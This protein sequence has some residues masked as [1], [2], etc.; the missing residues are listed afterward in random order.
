MPFDNDNVFCA[1]TGAQV[2]SLMT[3]S[4]LVTYP[5]SGSFVETE[6][7]HVMVISYVSEKPQYSY[8]QEISRDNFRLRDIVAED[9]RRLLHA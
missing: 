2:N 6:T 4:G 3:T 7:Y 5:T 1:C 8:L 9:L